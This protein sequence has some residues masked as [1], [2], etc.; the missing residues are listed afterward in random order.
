MVGTLYVNLRC[1][2]G[3]IVMVSKERYEVYEDEWDMLAELQKHFGCLPWKKAEKQS[4]TF[5]ADIV[6]TNGNC[7]YFVAEFK[8]NN[9]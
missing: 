3:G 9:K 8:P 7:E 6:N 4:W 1:N 5:V 2:N